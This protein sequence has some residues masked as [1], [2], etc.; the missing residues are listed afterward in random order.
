MSTTLSDTAKFVA[1]VQKF[2]FLFQRERDD[3][4]CG[5]ID[6]SRFRSTNFSEAL[7]FFSLIFAE[8]WSSCPRKHQI[9]WL[10]HIKEDL[11]E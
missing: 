8:E 11:K 7:G 5:G 9:E 6:L 4:P 10:K 1:F 2:H 3:I